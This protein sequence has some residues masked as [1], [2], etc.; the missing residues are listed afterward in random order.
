VTIKAQLA[1]RRR[2]RQ[3]VSDV[4]TGA[5][6]AS[7][8]VVAGEAG[9]GKS[10]LVAWAAEAAMEQQRTVLIGWCLSLSEDLPFL[11]V[12]DVLRALA[13]RDDGR[14]LKSV[15]AACPT[16]V[17]REIGRLL[18]EVEDSD[19]QASPPEEG[20]S[21]RRQRL[22]G[23][24]RAVLVAL[25]EATPSA[26]VIEDVH[27]ADPATRD[28]L[29]YLLVPSH[30]TG[31]PMV[32]ISRGEESDTGWLQDLLR[33][34]QLDWLSVQPLTRG[35]TAEQIELLRGSAPT[36]LV[37][38]IY[39]R[40]QGNPFF[41]EQL[42]AAGA[43]P[44]ALPATLHA[45][46]LQRLS[47]ATEVG[48]DVVAALAIAR[49]PLDDAA[50][51]SLTGR[52]AAA[53][54]EAVRDL[55]AARLLLRGDLGGRQLRHVLLAEAACGEMTTAELQDWHGR[56]GKHLA[57]LNES[58][59]AHEVA[60]HYAAAGLHA[61]ELG[62]R[63][64]SAQY[65]ES[66][67]APGQAGHDWQRVLALWTSVEQPE[68]VVGIGLAEVYFR[69]SA[70]MENA[71]DADAAGRLAEQALSRLV[72]EADDVTKVSLYYR[73]GIW[74]RVTSLQEGADLLEQAIEIGAQLPPTRDYVRALHTL[75]RVRH[76]EQS[77][78]YAL[79]T[80]LITR[81]LR[82]AQ[83]AG[84]RSEQKL[85]TAALA[86]LAKDRDDKE[87]ALTGADRALA[88]VVEPPDPMVDA[89]TAVYVTD[90]LLKYGD[91]PRVVD[92]GRAAMEDARHHGYPQAYASCVLFANIIEALR[93]LGSI[94]A[95]L[96]EI[97]NAGLELAGPGSVVAYGEV[98]AVD[99][100]AGLLEQ[101][102]AFW[103]DNDAAIRAFAGLAYA[104]EFTLRRCESWLWQGRVA[105][106]L[107]DALLVLEPLSA[108]EE[109]QVSGGLFVLAL[110]ACGD[111]AQLGRERGDD[112][113]VSS[114][115]ENAGHLMELRDHCPRDPL[116]GSGE[117][118]AT[119]GADAATWRAEWSR[120]HGDSDPTLWAAA[121]SAWTE[122]GRPH[123]AGYARWRQAEAL[124]MSPK[125]RAA[126]GPVLR[127]AAES[128][129]T[130]V[131]LSR[132]IADLAQRARIG[133]LEPLVEP[134]GPQ[135]ATTGFGL[136]ERELAV[137]AL[138]GQ[139]RTNAEIGAKLFISRKTASVHVTNILRK[140]GVGSR[141]Q[142]AAM[143]AHAGLIRASQTD[144]S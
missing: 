122:I 28:L 66:V 98:A 134:A 119:K 29:E 68:T 75:A 39:G 80:E 16:Y 104:H 13:E 47:Q 6:G 79:Q 32:L 86:G 58:S 31:L 18:P 3:V 70:A 63:S 10:R 137:L 21:W 138:V 40:A 111:L 100:T 115:V 114:A 106:A 57:A 65:A 136:T 135:P 49:R 77:G 139:G 27:W 94:D 11:P 53:I 97:E 140:L 7:A 73:A 19:D 74:R 33:H 130:H 142:A 30:R 125:G 110:Q 69:A 132:A 101:A 24:V 107:A 51:C 38:D 108:T 96:A 120:L 12:V 105:E 82:A 52:P 8:L 59:L 81:A 45:L 95:A 46:L 123:R 35:E 93:E 129:R 25:A 2:E 83:D 89:I 116:A 143:A 61:E 64:R 54:A 92:I 37:G 22:F 14:L 55:S 118:P 84:L 126:A 87:D 34:G 131:P 43:R 133:L 26:V 15:L 109:S 127:L 99:C 102:R 91:L 88:M 144:D 41:T 71:G 124:L 62:W 42:V 103:D 117:L 4:L 17:R 36:R 60:E 141:V 1:G 67:Y 90:I 44:A 48:L 9:I 85:L 78:N 50:L 113:L 5:S 121:A 128:A 56:V 72:D 76:T 112:A 23:A 20:G